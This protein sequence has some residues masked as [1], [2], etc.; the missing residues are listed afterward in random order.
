MMLSSSGCSPS[1]A[2][3]P[4]LTEYRSFSSDYFRAGYSAPRVKGYYGASDTISKK[5]AR[6]GI[7]LSAIG[8]IDVKYAAYEQDLTREGQ[9]VPF[10]AD[11]VSLSLSG[12]GTLTGSTAA[13]TALA[14]VDTGLKGAKSAYDSDILARKTVQ[15]L[16]KQMRTNRNQIKS[17]IIVKLG[18][19]IDRYPLELAMMDVEDYAAAGTLTAGLIGIDEQA[20]AALAAS[21]AAKVTEITSAVYGPNQSTAIIRAYLENGGA[22]AQNRLQQWLKARNVHVSSF[23]FLNGGQFATLR[24]EF[25]QELK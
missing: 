9:Q 4:D 20:S 18:L 22:A 7:V 5:A 11:V 3:G 1:I 19:G 25:V 8:S 24:D 15:F 2:G 17:A 21:E 6:N 23:L 13:K 14:A 10:V 16:Q 12:A